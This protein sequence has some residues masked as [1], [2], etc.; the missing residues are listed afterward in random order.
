MKKVLFVGA[1]LFS[2]VSAAAEQVL[3]LDQLPRFVGDQVNLV[4]MSYVLFKE[5]PCLLPIVHAKDMLGGE[6]RYGDGVHK[7]CWGL[8]LRQEVII[9][10]DL[11]DSSPPAPIS[12]YFSAILANNGTA[13]ITKSLYNKKN[14]EP[15]PQLGPDRWCQKTY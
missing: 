8:T 14:Y 12:T 10:D 5:R 9:V 1:L 15:C 13:R 2:D 7:L 11:G 4:D 3:L 6:V